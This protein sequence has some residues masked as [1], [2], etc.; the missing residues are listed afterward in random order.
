MNSAANESKWRPTIVIGDVHGSTYWKKA[1]EDNPGYRYIF[2]GDYLDPY[3]NIPEA[4]FIPEAQLIDNLKEIIQLKKDNPEDVILLLGNHDL[5]YFCRDIPGTSG[6]YNY[7]IEEVVAEIFTENLPLFTYAFQEG[8][9]IFTH[10]GI[11]HDWF[12]N[13]FKGDLT[14]NIADQL[15]NPLKEQL[16]PLHQAGKARGG[17]WYSV[18]GIFWADISELGNPLQGYIQY[19]GHNRVGQI[20]V[21]TKNDGQITFCDC[22]YNN[23][24]LKLDD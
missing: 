15:N 2:I 19:A 1:V 9:R 16:R 10:A 22:L 20:T 24:Y 12:V 6:R 3:D 13:E 18:G 11:A 8:K 5:H 21:Q 4:Q 7:R 23:I 17:A 14:K